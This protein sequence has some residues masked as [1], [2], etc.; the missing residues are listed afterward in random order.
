MKTNSLF[1]ACAAGLFLSPVSAIAQQNICPDFRWT[2]LGTAGGPVPT[3][4]RSEPANLLEAGKQ[5]IMVDAGDGAADQFARLGGNVAAIDA[6]F[7]SHH[8]QDHT[9]GLAGVIGLRWATN[10]PGVLRIYGPPGTKT[11]VDGI[12]SSMT[13]SAVVGYG[14]GQKS[15]PPADG[16]EVFELV[17]G[18]TMTMGELTVRAAENSH[19]SETP[20]LADGRP[21]ASLSYRFTLD[22]RSITYTGDTGPSAAVVQLAKGSDILVSEVI[23]VQQILDSMR[24][25][26]FIQ[27]SMIAGMKAH[28]E[29]HHLTPE[30][31]GQLAADAKVGELVLTHYAISPGPLRN[32]EPALRGGVRMNFTGATALA[33]DLSSFDVG[34]SSAN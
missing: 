23:L 6:V 15:I 27:P 33:R 34:C 9:A 18:S 11:M 5:I 25:N 7:L 19:F 22:K 29:K 12:L 2:T 3:P 30:A 21:S 13:A 26:S 1:A 28:F 32:A 31:A 14:L 8:H 4:E 16:V 24:A 20:A 10:S 17:G